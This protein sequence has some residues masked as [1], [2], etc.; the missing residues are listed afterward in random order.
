MVF[1]QEMERLLYN[2]IRILNEKSEEPIVSS[3]GNINSVLQIIYN[4]SLDFKVENINLDQKINS[5]EVE[6][7]TSADINVVEGMVNNIKHN[8]GF[9]SLKRYKEDENRI[10]RLL[11]AFVIGP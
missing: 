8:K 5:L 4:M 11:L 7:C 6:I 2:D 3:Y 9:R 1:D 10:K